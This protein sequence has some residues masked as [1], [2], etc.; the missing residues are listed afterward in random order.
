MIM[1]LLISTTLALAYPI[2]SPQSTT[3]E[4]TPQVERVSLSSDSFLK[5]LRQDLE[6]A[7]SVGDTETAEFLRKLI[8]QLLQS[9]GGPS[10]NT[11][12]G[13]NG[14]GPPAPTT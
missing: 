5:R 14:N 4:P 2:T 7:E 10:M 6:D 11:Q 3:V 9:G 8:E 1:S 12:G 13:G